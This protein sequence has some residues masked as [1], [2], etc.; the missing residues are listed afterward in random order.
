MEKA[1]NSLFSSIR[2]SV[3]VAWGGKGLATLNH[4]RVIDQG[5]IIFCRGGSAS[6]YD[7]ISPGLGHPLS[8]DQ[9]LR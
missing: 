2:C 6:A 1:Q 8:V 3:R 5:S 7:F 4:L 9:P